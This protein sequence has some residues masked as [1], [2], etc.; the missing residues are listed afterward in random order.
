MKLINKIIEIIT[1]W[2]ISIRPSAY[3]EKIATKRM[4]ICFKCEHIKYN[5]DIINFYYCGECGCPLNKKVYAPNKSSCPKNKW[6][7]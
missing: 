1:A 3:R 2:V 5:T 4:S 7:I 6:K